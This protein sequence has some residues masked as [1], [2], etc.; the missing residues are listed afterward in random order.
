[1][2]CSR[3]RP[4]QNIVHKPIGKQKDWTRLWHQPLCW[5]HKQYWELFIQPLPYKHGSQI[6]CSTKMLP[7]SQARR[8]TR[9]MRWSKIDQWHQQWPVIC[10]LKSWGLEHANTSCVSRIERSS[11]SS[12]SRS[13]VPRTLSRKIAIIRCSTRPAGFILTIPVK[14]WTHRVSFCL[15]LWCLRMR[16]TISSVPS[17]L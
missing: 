6:Q 5:R 3:A 7:S 14:Y 16:K 17:L 1:M 8:Q 13:R 10:L 15:P 11:S 9:Q 2:R 4:L 12:R